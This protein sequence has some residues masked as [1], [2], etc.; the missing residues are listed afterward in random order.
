MKKFIYLLLALPLLFLSCDHENFGEEIVT[1]GNSANGYGNF[2]SK[3]FLYDGVYEIRDG[4]EIDLTDQQSET[5]AGVNQQFYEMATIQTNYIYLGS[6]LTAESINQGVY[7]PA[8]FSN[9]LKKAI[10]VSFS[11]PV[12]SKEIAPKISSFRDAVIDAVGDKDFSGAQ[13]QLF[14]YKMKEFLYYKEVKMAFGANVNIGQLFSINT[15][16]TNDRIKSN[17]ALFVDFSQIYFNAAMDIPDDGNIYLNEEVRQKYLNKN[18]VY[19]NSVNF[20]RKGV[21]LVESSESY[22]TLSI[23]IRLAF[24]A[25][26]VSGELSI[27]ANTK[28][29]LKKAEISICIIGG[30]GAGATKTVKGFEE[31][32]NFIINGG[33]YSKEV[34][35][36]PISFSAGY[37]T[38]NSMFVS[39]FE[40]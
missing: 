16:V 18:P 35:G 39:E 4:K 32:Q 29:I 7:A 36:V 10:T 3:P 37:A 17:T 15:A 2:L 6:P 26:I 27:D 38:D 1:S 22:S 8:G 33:V 24:N 34:Y 31:F 25:K 23:A 9:D 11:L 13:S 5:R 28:E 40:L 19:V 12:R 21:L 30:D 20:G 14:S